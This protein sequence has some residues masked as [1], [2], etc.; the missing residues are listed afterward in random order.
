MALCGVLTSDI[1]CDFGGD[2]HYRLAFAY[3][4]ESTHIS[5]PNSNS[6]NYYSEGHLN[7]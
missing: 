1:T 3:M 4:S 2:G 6:A 5:A 7:K